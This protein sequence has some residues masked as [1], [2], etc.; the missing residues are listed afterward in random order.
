M[1]SFST[2]VGLEVAD[3][4][5]AVGADGLAELA[6]LAGADAAELLLEEVVERAAAACWRP[7]SP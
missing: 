6:G 2:C 3:L 5:A 7:R 1:K 4:G